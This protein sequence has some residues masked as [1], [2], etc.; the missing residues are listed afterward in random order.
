MASAVVGTLRILLEANAAKVESEFDKATL[1]IGQFD[2]FTQNAGK[3][4]NRMLDSFSG[5]KIVSEATSMAAA[6][7]KV[8]GVS[9]LTDRELKRVAATV[10]EATAKLRAMGAEIPPSIQKLSTEMG[11]LGNTSVTTGTRLGGLSGILGKLGPLLPIASVAGLA[12]GLVRLG[13]DALESA[14]RITDLSAKTGIG[15]VAIQRMEAVAKQTGSSLETFTSAAFKLG[16]NVAEGTNKARDAVTALGLSYETLRAMRPEDQFAAVVKAL[17]SVESTQERNRLGVALFG[18][19]FAEIAAS[20]EQGYSEIANA[21]TV[22]SDAQIRALDRAGDRWQKFKSD[23]GTVVTSVLGEFVLLVDGLNAAWNKLKIFQIAE[24]IGTGLS[25]GLSPQQILIGIANGM[26]KVASAAKDIE[27]PTKQ[28]AKATDELGAA[29]GRTTRSSERLV[30]AKRQVVAETEKIIPL[31]RNLA[32]VWSLGTWEEFPVTMRDSAAAIHEAVAA[33]IPLES[34]GA[35]VAQQFD[36]ALAPAMRQ[37]EGELNEMGDSAVRNVGKLESAFAGVA[38]SIVAAIQGGGNI[39]QA[40]GSQLG[41]NLANKF[42]KNFGDN[43]MGALPDV[44]GSAINALIPGLGALLGPLISKIGGFFKGLFG[45]DPAIKAARTELEGFQA[46][47]RKGLTDQQRI[48]SGN[49]QW[50][51]DIIAIRDAFLKVGKSEEEALKA[52]EALWDTD[53]PERSKRAMEEIQRVLDQIAREASGVT[54]E[55]EDIADAIE[56]IPDRRV[57]VE[58]DYTPGEF[59]TTPGGGPETPEGPAVPPPG[60]DPANSGLASSNLNFSPV[61]ASAMSGLAATPIAPVSPSPVPLSRTQSVVQ[62]MVLPVLVVD[63]TESDTLVRATERHMAERGIKGNEFGLREV[64][65]GI[66]EQVVES[67]MGLARG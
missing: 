44:L 47:L 62:N 43:I 19:Q 51:M 65:T 4:L 52:A 48:E 34:S 6:V 16:V 30:F 2:K 18:K 64:L 17:E 54:N 42:V 35:S 55:I 66:I 60:F 41:L 38:Q 45:I 10:N 15:T 3:N 31:T 14:S 40:A 29:Q 59:P 24:V 8:G 20:I 22:S 28:A 26:N 25:A 32:M 5:Q 49:E 36:V 11:H 13:T 53:N 27:L 50:K 12:T 33:M 61:S 67:K 1:K 7:Q 58:V 23:F 57:N 21:A 46:Q 39:L 37:F 63:R 9:A 56:N